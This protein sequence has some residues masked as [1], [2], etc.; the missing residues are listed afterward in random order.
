MGLVRRTRTRGWSGRVA[1]IRHGWF[2]EDRLCEDD[3]VRINHQVVVF[4]AADLTAESSFW[5][6][7]LGGTVDAEDDWHMVLVDGDPRVGVQLAPDHVP[8]DWP[9]GNPQQIHL[10]L[11]V[12]DLDTAHEEVMSLGAKL[13]QPA[14]DSDG[15]DSFQVYADPAGHPFCLCWVKKPG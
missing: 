12:D 5:A 11:W 13:L 3:R 8:P 6:G 7:L 1:A 10:D 9:D 15:P 14:A 4:D 2:P